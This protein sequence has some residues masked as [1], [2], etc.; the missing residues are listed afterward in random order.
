MKTTSL[1]KNT[2]VCGPVTRGC[3]VLI[4]D[5]KVPRTELVRIAC[6]DPSVTPTD[7]MK[8][9]RMLAAA[10]QLLA[11]CQR[12]AEF[13][14]NTDLGSSDLKAIVAMAR[15]AARRATRPSG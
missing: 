1:L 11:V 2:W 6:L 5:G 7:F 14:V 3:A 8:I 10:P 15:L 9:A 13:D 12:L 4:D